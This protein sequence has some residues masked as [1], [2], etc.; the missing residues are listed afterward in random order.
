MENN[1]KGLHSIEI[2]IIQSSKLDSIPTAH[3]VVD[4]VI[5]MVD[6]GNVTWLY[7]HPQDSLEKI[8]SLLKDHFGDSISFRS[9]CLDGCY[10][11]NTGRDL[12][13]VTCYIDAVEFP[14]RYSETYNGEY[15][16]FFNPVLTMQSAG[17]K[18]IKGIDEDGI[19]ALFEALDPDGKL[20][21]SDNTYNHAGNSETVS[22]MYDVNFDVIEDGKIKLVAAKFHH[23]GDIRGN[24]GTKYLFAVN[25]D[26][27]L[28][29][30]L[31]P[32]WYGND[33]ETK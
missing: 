25:N 2:K 4:A 24:Y 3:R 33:E 26:E 7:A 31:Y 16:E 12:S 29:E 17:W 19:E 11:S 32:S 15:S 21:K 14:E 9:G 13:G 27:S 22:A 5:K 23:G 28:Y 6:S 10:G 18:L 30:G 1:F 20:T 8:Q